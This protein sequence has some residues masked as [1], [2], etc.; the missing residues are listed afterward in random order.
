MRCNLSGIPFFGLG[1]QIISKTTFK[2]YKFERLKGIIYI[3]DKIYGGLGRLMREKELK[4]SVYLWVYV[5][6]VN[7]INA[8][9]LIYFQIKFRYIDGKFIP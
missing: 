9:S 1:G 8:I 6:L 2:T 7:F 5:T 3:E 4:F